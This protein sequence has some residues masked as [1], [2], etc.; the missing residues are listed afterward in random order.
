V[1][2]LP[3]SVLAIGSLGYDG[4]ANGSTNYDLFLIPLIGGIIGFCLGTLL[5]NISL[6]LV[7]TGGSIYILLVFE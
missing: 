5:A 6:L 2:L 1:K 7:G 4:S 3:L